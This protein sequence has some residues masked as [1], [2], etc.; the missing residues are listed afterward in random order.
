MKK[1]LRITLIAAVGALVGLS[2]LDLGSEPSYRGKTLTTWFRDFRPLDAEPASLNELNEAL[3]HLGTNCYSVLLS[4]LQQKDSPVLVTLAHYAQKQRL[5][6]IRIVPASIRHWQAVY[7]FGVLRMSRPCSSAVVADLVRVYELNVS[8]SSQEAV[9]TILGTLGPEAEE[10]LPSLLRG[11]NNTNEVAL[12][13][14]IYAVLQVNRAHPHPELVVP[15]LTNLLHH[16]YKGVRANSAMALGFFGQNARAAVPYLMPLV[17]DDEGTVRDYANYA[18]QQSD[19]E[20]AAKVTKT[21]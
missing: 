6:P 12:A 4:M 8:S 19:P 16:P 5:I 15:A 21:P 2:V 3:T 7:G 1:G 10:A 18:L 13:Y 11:L 20:A 9:T 14:T 17:N